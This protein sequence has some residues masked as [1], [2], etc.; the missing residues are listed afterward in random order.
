MKQPIVDKI[1]LS[2]CQTC[3]YDKRTKYC[4]QGQLR[5]FTD[6]KGNLARI[7]DCQVYDR[8]NEGMSRI[9]IGGKK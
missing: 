8:D 7:I 1:E 6:K 5:N 9:K 3:K 4:L 2:L